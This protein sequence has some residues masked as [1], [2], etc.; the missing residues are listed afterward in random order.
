[1]NAGLSVEGR[2]REDGVGILAAAG[3]IDIYTAPQF[4]E[5]MVALIEGGAHELVVDLSEVSF[6]DST[7]LGV[8][9]GGVKRLH[10]L[11]GHMLLVVA[12]T[13]VQRALSVTGLD[14]V[15]AVFG[16]REA[17]LATL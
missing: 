5:R 1:M 13:P 15:F 16:T 12:G 10:P 8:L 6:I 3:E 4:K 9:I 7:A 14:R 11:G 2:L 17:A